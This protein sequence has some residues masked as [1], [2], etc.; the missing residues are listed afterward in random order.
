LLPP[1]ALQIALQSI[2]E[3]ERNGHRLAT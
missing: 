1:R 2:A 3:D